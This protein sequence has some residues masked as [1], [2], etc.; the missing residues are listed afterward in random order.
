MLSRKRFCIYASEKQSSS[1]FVNPEGKFVKWNHPEKLNLFSNFK[2]PQETLVKTTI[3]NYIKKLTV[4]FVNE[5][6]FL[7]DKSNVIEQ[8]FITEKMKKLIYI[9][10]SIS[11]YK[12]QMK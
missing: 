4:G 5:S 7:Y 1:K 12:V 3:N 8:T 9:Y 6:Y 10:D 2:L 11:Y